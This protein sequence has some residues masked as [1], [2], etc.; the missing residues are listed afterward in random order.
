MINIAKFPSELSHHDNFRSC[1]LIVIRNPPPPYD[2]RH[3]RDFIDAD[4]VCWGGIST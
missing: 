3:V 1:H 4:F 2:R